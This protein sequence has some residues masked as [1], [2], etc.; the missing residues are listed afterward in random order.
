[1]SFTAMR[2]G[3]AAAM[4]AA[5]FAT[6]P[7]ASPAV[8]APACPDIPATVDYQLSFTP[9]AGD[10]GIYVAREKGYFSAAG[11]NINIIGGNGA[12]A[13]ATNIAQGTIMIG[14]SDMPSTILGRSKGQKIK[15]VAML[16]DRSSQSLGSI[17]P[18]IKT[19]KDI[20]GHTVGLGVGTGDSLLLPVMMKING[21]DY[22]KVKLLNVSPA[23]YATSLLSG[24]VDVTATY[25]DGSFV[26]DTRLAKEQGKTV[27]PI[28]SVAN[29]LDIYQHNVVASDDTIAQHPCFVRAVVQAE[30]KGLEYGVDHPDEAAAILLRAVP[31]LNA[32]DVPAQLSYLVTSIKS[33]AF[34]RDGIGVVEA[35]K[36][37][38][39]LKTIVEAYSLPSDIKASDVYTNEFVK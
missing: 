18:A 20:E 6:M 24:Q 1:M 15:S 28:G 5:A 29:G 21:A 8:A 14:D 30:I 11:V 13:T 10:F 38:R 27:Y 34:T 35:D 2:W 36:M 32:A 9:Y 25:L 12:A 16:T 3:I 22:S 7:L 4:I 37:T 39:T 19:A 31:T 23:A 26:S 17:N 33:P